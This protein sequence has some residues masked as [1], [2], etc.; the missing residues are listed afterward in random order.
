MEKLISNGV[1]IKKV[2]LT[3][4][5]GLDVVTKDGTLARI[6]INPTESDGGQGGGQLEVARSTWWPVLRS[7]GH[8][9]NGRRSVVD[10]LSGHIEGV[11]DPLLEV[12][13]VHEVLW[14]P[15][16]HLLGVVCKWW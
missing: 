7:S 15:L 3:F 10:G 6:A 1:K 8:I 13:D 11:E 12:V 2:F 5:S 16:L 14:H 9:A 4:W